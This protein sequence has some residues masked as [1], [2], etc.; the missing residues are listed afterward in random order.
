MTYPRL[1]RQPPTHTDK[2]PKTKQALQPA[3][4]EL[5]A[6][7][8]IAY[9]GLFEHR[10]SDNQILKVTK[11]I[12]YEQLTGVSIEQIRFATH[13]LIGRS[14]YLPSIAEF[15][16]CCKNKDTMSSEQAWRIALD[17]ASTKG[18]ITI[19]NTPEAIYYA[20]RSAG[21]DVL[22][23]LDDKKS[24]GL[25]DYHYQQVL[26]RIAQGEQFDI[27]QPPAIEAP[28]ALSN[29]ESMQKLRKLRKALDS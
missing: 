22:L 25:F 5:F 16:D 13:I 24:F 1:V 7:F 6:K 10:Y 15:L 17:L 19:S 4:D 29:Q 14:K 18:Q 11:K 26:K 3:V 20:A 27:P 23:E 12:W 9:P 8:Q 21:W 28:S 2:K